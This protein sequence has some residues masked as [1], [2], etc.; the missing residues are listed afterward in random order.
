MSKIEWTNITW[1]PV[2]GC[3][4]ISDG[5]Q[6]CYAARMHKRLQ[7]MYSKKYQQDFNKVTF[8]DKEYFR[9]F[10]KKPKKIFVNSMS[11]TFHDDLYCEEIQIIL[12]KIRENKQH[13]FQIL[14]KRSERLQ[15]FEYP[16]NVWLGVTVEFAKYKNRIEDL[17][18]TDA[19]VKFL[20][21]FNRY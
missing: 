19:K 6:N 18:K 17:K 20:S 16:E 15:F 21:G 4:P 10:C 8:H 2:T 9:D 5:C 13:T 1:N 14:T 11:D 12:I 7:L 3:T